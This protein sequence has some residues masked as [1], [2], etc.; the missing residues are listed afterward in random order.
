MNVGGVLMI[1]SAFSLAGCATA[2]LRED[3]SVRAPVGELVSLT[4]IV[5]GIFLGDGL[6]APVEQV[7]G[8]RT[9]VDGDEVLG[10]GEGHG[11]SSQ[12][13]SHSSISKQVR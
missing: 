7:D 4:P 8:V 2:A 12:H 1:A 13:Q 5:Q 11:P 3:A 10:V 6:T 9:Q